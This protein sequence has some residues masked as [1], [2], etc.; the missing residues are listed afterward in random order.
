MNASLRRVVM[1][2]TAASAAAALTALSSSSAVTA[3]T[4][5]GE[6]PSKASVVRSGD[7]K[8]INFEPAG[9]AAFGLPQGGG[10]VGTVCPG[11]GA[12]T[13]YNG[14]GEPAVRADSGGN[15][16]ASSENGL[17]AGTEAWKSLDGGKHYITLPSPNAGS[18]S[19]NTGFAPGGGDT[20]LAVGDQQNGAGF[21]PLYVASLNLADIDVS[22]SQDGGNSFSLQPLAS[23]VPVDDREW[24]AADD[25]HQGPDNKPVD[26]GDKVCISYHDAIQNISVDCDYAGGTLFLQHGS[27]IDAD[28]APYLVANNAIGNLAIA[29]NLAPAGQTSGDHNIYQIFTGP[30]DIAGTTARSSAGPAARCASVP[31]RRC[32]SATTRRSPGATSSKRRCSAWLSGAARRTN[33]NARARLLAPRRAPDVGTSSS[34]TV[35]ETSPTA[36]RRRA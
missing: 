16:Y 34:A 20:D 12:D 17:G 27:A 28:H 19:N 7:A 10:S 25:S 6:M 8:F 15:F 24:I 35:R 3:A 26:G 4:V 18:T 9:L 5:S 13:C 32:H 22:A 36:Q 30:K 29:G 23:R 31:S 1:L 2:S 21:Y 14:A 33:P 11:D